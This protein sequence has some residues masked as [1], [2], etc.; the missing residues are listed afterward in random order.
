M[1][2][3]GGLGDQID[4]LI[5]SRLSSVPFQFDS[6]RVAGYEVYNNIFR[7]L[8]MPWLSNQPVLF[9]YLSVGLSKFGFTFYNVFLL[10]TVILNFVASYLLFKRFKFKWAY[11]LMF[12]FS[13]YFWIHLGVHLALTQIWLYALFAHVLLGI[14]EAGDFK[15]RR[16]VGLS[17]LIVLAA[18]I[19]NY[20]GF[21]MLMFLATYSF[22]RFL[23]TYLFTKKAEGKKLLYSVYVSLLALFLIVLLLMPYFQA[24]YVGSSK[25]TYVNDVIERVDK[26]IGSFQYFSSRPWYFFIPPVKNPFVGDVGKNTLTY[27]ENM[28]YY[29][30]DDYFP[31]EHSGNYFGLV[32]LISLGVLLV[33]KYSYLTK[34]NKIKIVSLLITAAVLVLFMQPPFYSLGGVNIYTPGYLLYKLVPMFR[35][36]ARLGVLVHLCLLLIFGVLISSLKRSSRWFIVGLVLVTLLGTYVPIKMVSLEPPPVYAY[37]NAEYEPSTYFVVY[38]YSKVT[39]ALFWLPIH[40]QLLVNP[41]GYVVGDFN[42]KKFTKA[43]PTQE[44]LGKLIE[45]PA[46]VLLLDKHV[47]EGELK[48]FGEYV[49][50]V[51]E[52]GEY[53][54]FEVL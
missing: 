40:E 14:E 21:F 5:W 19:S 46:Q 33:T 17:L 30:A 9:A 42:S 50:L 12:N 53:L 18:M 6:L 48:I 16:F 4:F 32:F 52:V 31:A 54:V 38:P 7:S 22:T 24:S 45:S 26:D 47:S 23:V 11:M 36:T 28:D 2:I 10:Q 44:G 27:I 35:V 41:R 15:S 37:L 3:I 39:E 43:L 49:S 29:L 20:I 51:T 13:A 25:D 8:L 1:N 34:P